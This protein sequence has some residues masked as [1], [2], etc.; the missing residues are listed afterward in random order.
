MKNKIKVLCVCAVGI[1]RSKYLAGYLRRKGYATKFGGADPK[2]NKYAN[3]LLAESVE[4][5]DIII[6]L[7]K[8]L[9]PI[10]TK[11]FKTRGKKIITLDV[12]DSKRLIPE[13]FAHLRELDYVEF[14]K[15]WTRPQI[16]K[17]IKQYLPLK[18]LR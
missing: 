16:R 3:P 10:L 4:W 13:E 8:R 18:K 15:K 7:R 9:K 14:Q 1:N 17:A 6:V 2:D 12:T 5:A 11:K